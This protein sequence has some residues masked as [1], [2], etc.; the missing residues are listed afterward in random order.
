MPRV[1]DACLK[2]FVPKVGLKRL[3]LKAGWLKTISP[4]DEGIRAR[5]GAA[6]CPAQ[7]RVGRATLR[8]GRNRRHGAI[9][10]DDEPISRRRHDGRPDGLLTNRGR[11]LLA[12]SNSSLLTYGCSPLLPNAN[13]PLLANTDGKH[14]VLP[15]LSRARQRYLS[16][17][18]AE[19]QFPLPGA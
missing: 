5:N 6:V 12:D 11:I 7:A 16:H 2:R 8:S 1:T 10:I 17:P 14:R 3:V 9:G 18:P 19:W 15:Q 4:W 13:G